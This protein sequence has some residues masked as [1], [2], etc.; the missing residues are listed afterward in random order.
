MAAIK[1]RGRQEV[2]PRLNCVS[3]YFSGIAQGRGT[4]FIPRD[5]SFLS[6]LAGMRMW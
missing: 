6:G 3:P 1:N 5:A 4:Y 2:T